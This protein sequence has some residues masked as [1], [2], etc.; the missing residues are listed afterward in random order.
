MRQSNTALNEHLPK[1]VLCAP[2][3]FAHV[4]PW[5]C[6]LVS[7]ACILPIWKNN[8]SFDNTKITT[9]ALKLDKKHLPASNLDDQLIKSG[10]Y[11]FLHI[12]PISS[13]TIGILISNEL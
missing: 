7:M 4:S 12:V 2:V 13:V 9:S 10:E 1:R 11:G 6:L 3:V 8:P 5:G